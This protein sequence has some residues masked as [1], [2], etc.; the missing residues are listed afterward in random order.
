MVTTQRLRILSALGLGVVLFV[1][2]A[3]A[4]LEHRAGVP[5]LHGPQHGGVHERQPHG[6]GS[7]TTH[8]GGLSPGSHKAGRVNWE[9]VGGR[10][11]GSRTTTSL[12][13]DVHVR[14][15]EIPKHGVGGAGIPVW[16]W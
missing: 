14:P 5:P 1:A 7:I 2:P 9:S 12:L 8:R 13:S 11:D 4:E 15:G 16:R 6:T 3:W 10:V